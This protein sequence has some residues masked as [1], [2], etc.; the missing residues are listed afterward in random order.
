MVSLL[1]PGQTELDTREQTFSLNRISDVV[2]ILNGRMPD[3]MVR[4][5]I[6]VHEQHTIHREY[7]Y[8]LSATTVSLI[9]YTIYI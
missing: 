9:F 3:C 7:K 4:R 1:V 5:L 8:I 6:V 2:I